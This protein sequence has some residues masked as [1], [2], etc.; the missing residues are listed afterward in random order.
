MDLRVHP[1]NEIL[2]VSFNQDFSCFACGTTSGYLVYQTDPFQLVGC[3]NIFLSGGVGLVGMFSRSN[4]LS[5]VGND[6]NSRYTP[7]TVA[8]W[9]DDALQTVAEIRYQSE[10]LALR[11]CD[12]LLVV[13]LRRRLYVHGDLKQVAKLDTIETGDNPNAICSVSVRSNEGPLIISLGRQLGH[14]L[15][16]F[17]PKGFGRPGGPTGRARTMEVRASS[18]PLRALAINSKGHLFA[19]ASTS[20]KKIKVHT[21]T[22]KCAVLEEFHRGSESAEI[23][24]IVFS[25]TANYLAVASNRGTVHVFQLS[26]QAVW[27]VPGFPRAS[28][29]AQFRVPELTAGKEAFIACFAQEPNC[30]VVLTAAGCYY[31]SR[32]NPKSVGDMTLVH[33]G[34]HHFID[35]V[36]Y[37]EAQRHT[38]ATSGGSIPAANR[39]PDGLIAQKVREMKTSTAASSNAACE[40]RNS[41]EKPTSISDVLQRPSQSKCETP[42]DEVTFA[43]VPDAD[44]A[45]KKEQ[46]HGAHVETPD[47][48]VDK[49]VS[50]RISSI[51]DSPCTDEEPTALPDFSDD[52]FCETMGDT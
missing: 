24:S 48:S 15:V 43:G 11:Q 36:R 33:D 3:A 46:T 28:S 45:T 2:S 4:V 39:A 9:D 23:Y 30:V 14:V 13:V 5:L 20:G 41:Q 21:T 50:Q 7:D 25:T 18:S 32:F 22:N 19:S 6:R 27:K 12:D 31:K 1:V 10:I 35:T 51:C 52:D 47:P 34:L 40:P 26:H 37:A 16:V 8:L 38:P 42:S 49:H 17:Y 29:I 44:S